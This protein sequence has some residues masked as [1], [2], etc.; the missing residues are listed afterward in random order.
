VPAVILVHTGAGYRDRNQGW[1]ATELQ[2]AGFATLT[3][4]SFAA[5]GMATWS[6]DFLLRG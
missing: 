1:K 6:Q 3:Y 4:D 2:Q 5:R